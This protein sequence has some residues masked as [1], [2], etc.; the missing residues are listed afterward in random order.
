MITVVIP[1]LDSERVLIP[2]L[3]ALVPG[4]AEGLVC[5]VLLA[6]GGSRDET[7]TIADAAGCEFIGGPPDETRLKFA[8]ASARGTW[9]LFLDPGTA[10][11]EGW[12]R[13]VRAFL[14]KDRAGQRAAIFKLAI[15][16]PGLG[17][18][19]AEMVASTRLALT[20]TPRADQGLLIAKPLYLSLGGHSPGPRT[21]Q[22]LFGKIGSGRLVV[23]RT[24]ITVPAG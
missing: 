24:R 18:R 23:L 21:R 6:D 22:R 13:E 11:D 4:S 20:G 8:A 17:S 10:L 9:L 7:R 5:E 2:T 12:T 15:D 3:A 14:A 19:L 1:T 16:G